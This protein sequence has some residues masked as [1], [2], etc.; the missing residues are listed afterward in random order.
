MDLNDVADKDLRAR[1]DE[2]PSLPAVLTRLITLDRAADDYFDRVHELLEE[3]PPFAMRMLRISNSAMYAP[4]TRIT[5]LSH[6]LIRLGV[7]RIAQ[8]CTSAAVTRM[9]VPQNEGQRNLWIHSVQT[10]A[11]ARRIAG[12]E[13]ELRADPEEAY[14]AGLLH[15]IGRFILFDEDPDELLEV[16]EHGWTAP[17]QRASERPGHDGWD[18]SELGRRICG[19]W[20]L[21]ERLGRLIG[22]HHRYEP[23]ES[24]EL[25]SDE[26]EVLRVVQMADAVSL[27][28]MLDPDL[29]DRTVEER[30][31]LVKERCVHPSW[32]S[33]PI[34]PERLAMLTDL[35]LGDTEEMVD[36]L[37][38]SRVPG[39]RAGRR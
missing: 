29:V 26:R 19:C 28:L 25:E 27:L 33:P 8:V 34:T 13:P 24:D 9:F 31:R 1:L 10:A 2:L 36:A 11:A 5:T 21:P 7:N 18:H 20:G 30:I 4:V 35:I 15:D 39:V 3:D 14:L 16:E 32:E 37:G 38:L 23:G 6:A 12:A 17:G 22:E